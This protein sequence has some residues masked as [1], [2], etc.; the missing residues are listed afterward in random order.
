MYAMTCVHVEAG[1]IPGSPFTRMTGVIRD[2]IVS[3]ESPSE[4]LQE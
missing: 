2:T 1:V 4:A 3:T